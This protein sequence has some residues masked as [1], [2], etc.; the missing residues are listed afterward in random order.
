[1]EC[2]ICNKTMQLT[3]WKPPPGFDHM[4]LQFQCPVCHRFIYKFPQG[5]ERNQVVVEKTPD[6]C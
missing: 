2:P 6:G 4:L 1:M 5:F 3:D